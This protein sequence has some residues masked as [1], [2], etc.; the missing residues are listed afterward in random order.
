ML[1]NAPLILPTDENVPAFPNQQTK[2]WTVGAR[3]LDIP[4]LQ[5]K[6]LDAIWKFLECLAPH[7]SPTNTTLEE[8]SNHPK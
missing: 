7:C 8:V 6:S 5:P 3:E 1:L 4:I 2:D